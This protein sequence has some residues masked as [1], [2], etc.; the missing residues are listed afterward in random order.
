MMPFSLEILTPDRQF[1]SGQVESVILPIVD[2]QYGINAGHEATVTVVEPG[3]LRYCVGGAWKQV[4][5]TTGIAE[6]MPEY[7]VLLLSAAEY[8]EEI[9]L[10]RAEAA[11]KRA[12]DRLLLDKQNEQVLLSAQAALAR[13]MARLN[14][15]RFR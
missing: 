12:E 4:A 9:D 8:P 1:F 15:G 6:I 5:V 2:G 10:K 7:T 11:K 3:T 14:T 13:A